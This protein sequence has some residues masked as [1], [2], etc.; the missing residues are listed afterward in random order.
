MLLILMPTDFSSCANSALGHAVALAEQFGAELH[1][2][3]VV[4]LHLDD[5][6]DHP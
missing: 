3:H 4:V 2:L 1:L 5:P 6:T